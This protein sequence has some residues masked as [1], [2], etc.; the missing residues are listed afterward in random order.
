MVFWVSFTFL[1]AILRPTTVVI[2][3]L[4]LFAEQGI[5]DQGRND[6]DDVQ[7]N[8]R[9]LSEVVLFDDRVLDAELELDWHVIDF[10]HLR[11]G[12]R[13]RD[14]PLVARRG[15]M[16]VADRR[17]RTDL[18]A[19]GQIVEKTI[20]HAEIACVGRILILASS[21]DAPVVL[22]EDEGN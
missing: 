6:R 5:L 1:T 22:W 16:V 17:V 14:V 9:H 10:R 8:L 13:D 2:K 20:E 19:I 18:P 12:N 15:L 7:L 4:P 3:E 11:H 21:P